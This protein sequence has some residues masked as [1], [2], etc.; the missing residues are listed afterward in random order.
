MQIIGH[1]KG[2]P[3]WTQASSGEKRPRERGGLL[4]VLFF[5]R[6][7]ADPLSLGASKE[8][9]ALSLNPFVVRQ[10][11]AGRCLAASVFTRVVE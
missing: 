5:L 1:P 8:A 6:P 2:V 9:L 10:R 11:V 4:N 3:K 7:A